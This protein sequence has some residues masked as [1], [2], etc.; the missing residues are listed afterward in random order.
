ML[1]SGDLTVE[2]VTRGARNELLT[3]S[4]ACLRVVLALTGGSGVA[5]HPETAFAS[6]I[7]RGARTC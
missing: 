5:E 1:T 3:E 7:D 2:L 6:G 4:T